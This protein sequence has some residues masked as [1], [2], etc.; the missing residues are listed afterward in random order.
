MAAI[1]PQ[2]FIQNVTRPLLTAV[3]VLAGVVYA[4][5]ADVRLSV[6]TT[7]QGTLHAQLHAAEADNWNSPLREARGSPERLVFE[8]VPPGRY[9]IQ[10]FLDLNGNGK[11]DASLRGIPQEPVG[12]SG[13]PRP[14]TAKPSPAAS[15]FEHGAS[16]SDFS[17]N[18]H[19]P[20]RARNAAA[21]PD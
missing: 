9:A 3:L 6:N 11:L 7:E 19:R 16:I 15:A 18:L 5:A 17:I 14:G 12:F 8:N 20:G 21:D 4:Q 13:N 1:M 10:V 2:P